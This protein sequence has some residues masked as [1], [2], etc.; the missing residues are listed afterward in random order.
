MYAK[1]TDEVCYEGLACLGLPYKG[2]SIVGYEVE[3][4]IVDY[5][6]YR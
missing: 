1:L 3:E 6:Y 4:E 2:D 5:E